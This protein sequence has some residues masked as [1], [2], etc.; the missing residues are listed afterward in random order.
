MLSNVPY[1]HILLMNLT[2]SLDTLFIHHHSFINLH[3][4]LV[5]ILEQRH[6]V[7]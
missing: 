1:A 6:L 2:S 7:D 5:L 3:I 4:M